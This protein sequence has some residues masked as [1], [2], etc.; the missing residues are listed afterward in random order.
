MYRPADFNPYLHGDQE[1]SYRGAQAEYDWGR[2]DAA[3]GVP[4]YHNSFEPFT[5][6]HIG[7]LEQM[8]KI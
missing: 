7:W 8:G 6:W 5:W 4:Y 2:I 1:E 3:A